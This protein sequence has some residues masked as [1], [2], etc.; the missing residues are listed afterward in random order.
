VIIAYLVIGVLCAAHNYA[1][2]LMSKVAM[3]DPHIAIDLAFTVALWPIYLW[4]IVWI[5]WEP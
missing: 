3:R 1:K 4:T 5:G 2:R